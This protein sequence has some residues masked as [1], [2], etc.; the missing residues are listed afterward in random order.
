MKF[1][2]IVTPTDEQRALAGQNRPGV[3]V[4][5]GSA[6][7]GK[8]TTAL[9]RLKSLCY[10]IQTKHRRENNIAPIK[11][12]VLTFNRTLSGYIKNLVHSQLD[13][14]LKT[15]IEISTFSRWAINKLQNN[16][17]IFGRIDETIN[18][19]AHNA[20]ILSPKYVVKEVE[21][22][23]GRFLPENISDY[24]HTERTGRGNTPRVDREL[25]LRILNEIVNPYKKTLS[26]YSAVDWNDLAV[27]MAR[28]IPSLG[29]EIIIVDET[30]DFSANQLRA[31]KHHLADY[32][33][34]TFVTDTIQRIYA[35]GFTWSEAGFDVRPERTHRLKINYRNTKQIAKFAASFLR[36]INVE[37]DG[38]I[39]NLHEAITDGILPEVICGVYR[40][41][42]NYAIDFIKGNVNLN[43]ETI[44]F[45]HPLGGGCFSFLRN[46]LQSNNLSYRDITRDSDWCDEDVSIALSTL[47]SVKG[48]EFDYVFILGLSDQTTTYSEEN[49]DDQF[50]VLRKL[51]AM[52]IARSRKGVFLGYKKG[53]E[54]DLLQFLEEGTYKEVNL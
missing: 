41:Q 13:P 45:L 6:G 23:L 37:D 10:M 49:I 15:N 30:Q 33:T 53:E 11:I 2:S 35:R 7:S 22:L 24:L 36:G 43:V 52:A 17:Y 47:H 12:L 40:N 25:R 50:L 1:L 31:I 8:T 4:I 38:S 3:E 5:Y 44:A 18:T 19:L 32:H 16:P 20:N 46:K 9:L 28:N 39:P 42:I 27:M 48:L 21:Y 14:N 26:N 29:Y 34:I 54:S 51:L